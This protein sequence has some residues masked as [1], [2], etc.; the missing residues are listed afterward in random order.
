MLSQGITAS[1]NATQKMPF[2]FVNYFE[3]PIKSQ[4]IARNITINY[5]DKNTTKFSYSA[6][7]EYTVSKNG[8][9]IV[10]SKSG[11]FVSYENVFVLFADATTYEKI[12]G[13]QTV[14]DTASSG[15]GY[16][17][18]EG[19]KY[20]IRWYCDDTGALVFLNDS[21][22]RLTVNRGKS[23]IAYAKSTMYSDLLIEA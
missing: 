15:V 4:E 11:K 23:Y 12:D 2:D 13:M 9:N 20:N 18:T 10:D 6:E 8:T 14:I 22:A 5:S 21:G 3:S 1:S 17:F 7:G 19:S 16:Y